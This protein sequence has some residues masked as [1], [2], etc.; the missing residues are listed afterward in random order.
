MNDPDDNCLT[1]QEKKSAKRGSPGSPAPILI[2]VLALLVVLAVS[3][4]S[5]LFWQIWAYMFISIGCILLFF[6]ARSEAD[7]GNRK[8]TARKKTGRKYFDRVLRE[9]K[10]VR[11]KLFCLVLLL[12]MVTIATAACSLR[13]AS[14][15]AAGDVFGLSVS[16]AG[17]AL[18][19][20]GFILVGNAAKENKNF[21]IPVKIHKGQTIARS[22]PYSVVRL[23]GYSGLVVHV[24]SIPLLFGSL[25]AAIPAFFTILS[26]VLLARLDDELLSEKLSGYKRYAAK[27]RYRLVPA[28]W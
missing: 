15:D 12:F 10:T 18:M 13:F 2:T 28:F 5:V 25:T 11:G 7:N 9:L 17:A 19:I 26:L 16:I 6:V 1:R 24:I 8:K 21:G 14:K 23:P 22:G 4:G 20:S 27:V 3:A